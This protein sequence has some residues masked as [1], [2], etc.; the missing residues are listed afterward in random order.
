MSGL[1]DIVSEVVERL[2]ADDWCRFST[3]D[4]RD[5]CYVVG[6]ESYD[7]E[8]VGEIKYSN[9][10]PGKLARRA[11]RISTL[12]RCHVKSQLAQPYAADLREARQRLE[13]VGLAPE[14]I[15]AFLAG[16]DLDLTC[17]R[18]SGRSGKDF[19]QALGD[20]LQAWRIANGRAAEEDLDAEERAE[21]E[22]AREKLYLREMIGRYQIALD[23]GGRLD[24]L[25]FSDAQLAEASE[26]Y[27][28]GFHRATVVLAAA[29]LET[30]L[31]TAAGMDRFE[32]YSQLV[33][34]ARWLGKFGEDPAL[35]NC[36]NRVFSL[37]NRVVHDRY[38]P[39]PTEAEEV[40]DL[41]RRVVDHLK[42]AGL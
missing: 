5:F 6:L 25:G 24:A 11:G 41:A 33:E 23:R 8:P 22:T 27:L 3:A 36:S 19:L 31:K 9:W 30:H 38:P 42:A 15:D 1:K 7:R 16:G 34:K 20:F 12:G 26:C 35:P 18:S 2:L 28:Y 29:A 17:K 13:S 14:K 4:E 10:L 39:A 21:I 37:R 40:L 32:A